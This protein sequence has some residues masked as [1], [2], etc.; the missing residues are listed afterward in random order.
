[1]MKILREYSLLPKGQSSTGF[2]QEH[3]SGLGWHSSD[4]NPHFG[5]GTERFCLESFEGM[6][7]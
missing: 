6:V 7:T 2:L 3:E 4:C 1:M 5:K